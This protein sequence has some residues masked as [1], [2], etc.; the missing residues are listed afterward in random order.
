MVAKSYQSLEQIGD[1]FVASGKSYVNVKLKSGKVKSVRWYSEKEYTK[2]YSE[3]STVSA[4][5]GSTGLNTKRQK[6]ILGFAKGYITIFKGDQET[7]DE[8]FRMSIAR[9]ARWWGWYIV[10]TDEVPNNLPSGIEPVKLDWSLVG[11]ENG[12]LKTEKEVK[13]GVESILYAETIGKFVGNIGDRIEIEVVVE[14]TIPLE[15]DYGH[16]TMHFLRDTDG[17]LFVWTTTAKNWAVGSAHHIR[18]TIKAHRKYKGENQ[19]I[20]TRCLKVK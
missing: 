15:T 19:T 16:S 7:N 14:R 5:A 18:G 8:W 3:V 4:A 9:Y 1:V 20:L 11:T 6:D 2:M 10:S 12:I 13:E 17:N